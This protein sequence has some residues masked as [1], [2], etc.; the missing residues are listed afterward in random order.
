M[1][2]DVV[3]TQR[4][5]ERF[6]QASAP[7]VVKEMG[8]N[9]VVGG[10]YDKMKD[11][12][13]YLKGQK[14]RYNPGDRTWWA[15]KDS[16]TPQKLKNLQKKINEVNGVSEEV[17]EPE[18]KAEVRKEAVKGLFEKA[19]AMKLTGIR[20]IE[21]GQ[22]VQLNGSLYDL[23][24]EIRR[25]GGDYD[26]TLSDFT[27]QKTKPEE[28]ERLLQAV[29][30]QGD[31]IAKNT[32]ALSGKLPR[33]FQ[34]IKIEMKISER[35]GNVI[36]GGKTFDYN[37]DIK[38]RLSDVYFMKVD[39]VWAAPMH[40]VRTPEVDKLIHFFEEKEAELADKWKAERQAPQKQEKRP[41]RKGDNCLTCGGWVGAGDGY[42]VNW[43]D[44]EEGDFVWKVKHA[45]PKDCEAVKEAERIRQQE[46]RTKNDA[47]SN[48][49]KLCERSEYYVH[50]K[51][52]QPQGTEIEISGSRTRLY[53]GG[54]WVV[55]EPDGQHFWY[56]ENNGADGD[57]WSRNNVSTGGAGAI[58]YRVPY[59]EEAKILIEVAKE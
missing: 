22:L 14:F 56:V 10:P 25:A 58:G 1:A 29:D 11:L 38:A 28:F 20:F 12:L 27:I 50:G 8:S 32:S 15:P 36:I 24:T 31:L 9:L 7:V 19:L 37:Q 23:E 39:K 30:H 3:L 41:N 52:H 51:G 49:R 43:Y 33:N 47:R 6:V 53:G 13:T 34:H 16:L 35:G 45:D 46:A 44:S 21:K 48:L 26:A 4:V 57:D 17:A 59:T 18:D 2:T 54:V 55:I 40:K 42:L 5:V